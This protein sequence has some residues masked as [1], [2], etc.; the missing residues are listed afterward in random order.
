MWEIFPPDIFNLNSCLFTEDTVARGTSRMMS[1]GAVEPIWTGG[2]SSETG[3]MSVSCWLGGWGVS[4]SVTAAPAEAISG[5]VPRLVCRAH[6]LEQ[7]GV[8]PCD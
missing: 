1:E 3:L 6:A 8:S 5:Q 2:Q 4:V 7:T